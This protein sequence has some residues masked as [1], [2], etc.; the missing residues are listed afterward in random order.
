MLTVVC[1][2]EGALCEQ[3]AGRGCQQTRP[4][5]EHDRADLAHHGRKVG[6]SI[7]PTKSREMVH[8]FRRMPLLLVESAFKNS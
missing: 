5:E 8:N 7:L 1:V 6:S 2:T 3:E 4:E